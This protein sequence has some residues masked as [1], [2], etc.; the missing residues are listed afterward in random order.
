MTTEDTRKGGRA[1][2]R[3]NAQT[4]IL[5]IHHYPQ[6]WSDAERHKIFYLD[7]IIVKP[8]EDPRREPLYRFRLDSLDGELPAITPYRRGTGATARQQL[9]DAIVGALTAKLECQPEDIRSLQTVVKWFLRSIT[10]T[11]E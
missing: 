1:G 6:M 3:P 11:T 7:A 9:H 4:I 10:T 2:V 8:Q 5:A